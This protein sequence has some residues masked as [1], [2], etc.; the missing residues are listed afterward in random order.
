MS[1]RLDRTDGA[2]AWLEPNPAEHEVTSRI[3]AITATLSEEGKAAKFRAAL[4]SKPSFA[5]SSLAN[6]FTTIRMV[7]TKP[8]QEDNIHDKGNR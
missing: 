7:E 8:M 5:H 6:M 3:E 4:L 2:Q 1:E